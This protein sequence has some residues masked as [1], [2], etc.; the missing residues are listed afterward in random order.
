MNP[1]IRFD[2]PRGLRTALFLAILYQ[3]IVIVHVGL[4]HFFPALNASFMISLECL[5]CFGWIGYCFRKKIHELSGG[6]LFGISFLALYLVWKYTFRFVTRFA[7][8]ALSQKILISFLITAEAA[9]LSM[10]I[11]LISAR[12]RCK[13]GGTL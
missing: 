7:E 12:L 8:I 6:P 9:F 1:D 4:L 13:K 5:Y 10:L 2:Q 11:V 3:I